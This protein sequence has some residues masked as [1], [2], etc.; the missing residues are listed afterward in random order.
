MKKTMLMAAMLALT[1]L[2]I[3]APVAV[4][5]DDRDDGRFFGGGGFFV[6]GNDGFDF[7]GNDGFDFGDNDDFDFDDNDDF[8]FDGV[9]Q[10]NELDAESGEIDQ[11]FVVTGTGDNSNQC[12]GI[13]G[14]ANTGNVQNI[15]GL[16]QFDSDAD[17]FDFDFDD[18]GA[19]IDLSGDSTTTCDQ[20][21]NQA[22][23]AG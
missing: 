8:D 21:V 15:T 6:S 3:G 14:T 11:S 19:D 13:S 10:D 5:D 23:A 12:V 20:Q 9:N 4:A 18:S 17:D 2:A 16:T 7:G 1:V 22:A